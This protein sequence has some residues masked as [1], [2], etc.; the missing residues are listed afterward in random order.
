MTIRSD[1]RDCSRRSTTKSSSKS[2]DA[3]FKALE[4]R[5]QKSG[6]AKVR[7]ARSTAS[8]G[9]CGG[10]VAVDS[11]ISNTDNT[12]EVLR[13]FRWR[14]LFAKTKGEW[15]I[16]SFE[17]VAPVKPRPRRPVCDPQP[18][19]T[20]GGGRMSDPTG[21]RRR[22]IAGEGKPAAPAKKPS[23]PRCRPGRLPPKRRRCG[24]RPGGATGEECVA[25]PKASAAQVVPPMRTAGLI[26][27]SAWTD[28]G[29]SR[30]LVAVAAIVAGVRADR[31]GRPAPTRVR[32][33]RR[34]PTPRE[35]AV[36]AASSAAQTIFSFRSDKLEERVGLQGAHDDVVRQGL[37]QGR[38]SPHRGTANRKIAGQGGGPRGRPLRLR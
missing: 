29:W 10:I 28:A 15:L 27:G 19:R 32:R 31:P 34:S 6:G 18:R 3:V 1:S 24:R 20:E 11:K 14:V 9:L 17:S 12:A 37:R 5:K 2:T 25:T 26:G 4:S 21:P 30:C 13:H 23:A 16:S 7:D 33:R 35:Q 38:A 22:R 36:S 8:K